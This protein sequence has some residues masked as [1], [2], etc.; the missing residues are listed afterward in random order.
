MNIINLDLGFTTLFTNFDKHEICYF[1]SIGSSKLDKRIRKLMREQCEWM[2]KIKN[3]SREDITYKYN[4]MLLRDGYAADDVYC[5]NFLIQMTKF[6]DF[7]TI[8]SDISYEQ[9]NKYRSGIF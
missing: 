7:N 2:Q 1:D 9:I 8:K 5:V 6:D 4:D 3:I